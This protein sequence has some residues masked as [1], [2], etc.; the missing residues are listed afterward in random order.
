MIQLRDPSG[1]LLQV[2]DRLNGCVPVEV[3]PFEQLY[4]IYNHHRRLRVFAEKGCKCVQPGCDRVGVYLIKTHQ[5]AKGKDPGG[6]HVDVYDKD[7]NIM[8]VDHKHAIGTGGSKKN[9][10][11]MFPMCG[12]HNWAKGKKNAEY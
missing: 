9:I 10:E 2:P 12:E 11:N 1:E 3:L 7:F 5:P 6:F 4:T 8:T